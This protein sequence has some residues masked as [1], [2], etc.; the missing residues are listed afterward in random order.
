MRW[1]IGYLQGICSRW[2]RDAAGAALLSPVLPR[3]G[4]PRKAV[5]RLM[6]KDWRSLSSL[7]VNPHT[8]SSMLPA[9]PSCCPTSQA[10]TNYPGSLHFLEF[11]SFGNSSTNSPQGQECWLQ[12]TA[13]GTSEPSHCSFQSCTGCI[14]TSKEQQLKPRDS[15]VM[16]LLKDKAA[17][18]VLPN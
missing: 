10:D 1:E 14:T 13:A 6:L 5:C 15:W 7:A 16:F 3:A 9:L 18:C 17:E 4:F 12:S 2:V 11:F 8:A